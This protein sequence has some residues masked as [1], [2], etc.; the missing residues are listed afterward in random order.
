MKLL[1]FTQKVDYKDPI[2]GFFCGWIKKFS[3]NFDT[4]HVICL[5]EGKHNFNKN[6]TVYSLGKEQ[7]ANKMEYIVHFFGHLCSVSGKYDRVF[8]HM[9]QEYLL[10]GGIYWKLKKIPVYFWRNHP[11]GNI[12]TK[13]AM[14]FSEKIFCTSKKS[15]TRISSKSVLMPVGVD[16]SVFHQILQKTRVKNSIC[17][18]GRIAP[19]KRLEKGIE[20]IKK[21][22]DSGNQVSMTIIGSP[23]SKDELYLENLKNYVSINNLSSYVK[24]VPAVSQENLPEI[25]SS[26]EICL[27]LTKEGS[28]DKTIV[29][30][31][32]CG[33]IPVVSAK[34]FLGIIP[35]PCVSDDNIE[36]I[37]S[38]I[39][40]FLDTKFAIETRKELEKFAK[41][42]SLDTL[43]SKI[44]EEMS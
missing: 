33:C 31:S 13:I 20:I 3:E 1:I 38:T 6:V 19:V 41:N 43:I 23:L 22:I 44:L 5:E 9:N 14:F 40:K 10:L 8:V 25:Y 24:F 29:E 15:F 42:Q 36:E 27:N 2:L 34:S 30:A 32:S 11:D 12:F 37:S 16:Q 18:V 28:F 26:H 7:G 4:V 17:M 21:L 39:L 35:D